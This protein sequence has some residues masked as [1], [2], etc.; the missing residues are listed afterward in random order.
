LFSVPC[1]VLR[2]P[3]TVRAGNR[4]KAP[5]TGRGGVSE[6]IDAAPRIAHSNSLCPAPSDPFEQRE[7]TSCGEHV[8]GV[9]HGK[10]HAGRTGSLPRAG[11][12]K[13][14]V[15]RTV[16]RLAS[17]SR[18]ENRM[19]FVSRRDQTVGLPR[20]TSEV[21][22]RR[23][24]LWIWLILLPGGRARGIGELVDQIHHPSQVDLR[25]REHTD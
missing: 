9:G 23:R 16:D 21:A 14:R 7:R 22:V 8:V 15:D 4:A 24:E 2:D 13:D 17:V 5:V 6:H 1:P 10:P 20:L 19:K 3:V 25:N 12:I 18:A 11:A